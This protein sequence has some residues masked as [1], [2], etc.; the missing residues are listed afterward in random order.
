MAARR[1]GLQSPCPACHE[2]R[3][4]YTSVE[5]DVPYFGDTTQLA[6]ECDACGF[7]HSDFLAS[8]NRQ[9]TRHTLRVD[10]EDHMMVRVV[11]STSGTIRIPELGVLIEPGPASDGYVSNIE[12][13]LVRVEAVLGQLLRDA[14]QPEA[15]AECERRLGLIADAKAGRFA[16]TF[17]LEDPFG[18]SLVADA[19]AR[20]ELIPPPEAARLQTGA[21]A[22]E[23]TPEGPA[24][25]A[26]GSGNGHRDGPDAS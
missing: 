5:L 1:M 22:I 17:I 6:F 16:L 12:G 11:R 10:R 24:P 9:P 3:L 13:V 15:R 19:A 14:E 21:Y 26:T 18:N 23:M 20:E 4:F 25:T 2:R 8:R 7:R